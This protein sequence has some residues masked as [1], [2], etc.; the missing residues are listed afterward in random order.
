[1]EAAA[2]TAALNPPHIYVPWVTVNGIALGD[3]YQFLRTFVCAAYTGERCGALPSGPS[4]MTD[5]P[6]GN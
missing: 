4:P 1:M 5:A 3:G 6:A 2:A